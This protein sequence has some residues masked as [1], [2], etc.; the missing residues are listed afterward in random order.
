MHACGSTSCPLP[1]TPAAL[2]P[3]PAQAH[4]LHLLS[5]DG[6]PPGRVDLMP[7]VAANSDH[8]ATYACLDISLDP[9]PYAGVGGGGRV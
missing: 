8:L 9:Y 4:F 7:L 5:Q 6:I 1:L 2:L 3:S